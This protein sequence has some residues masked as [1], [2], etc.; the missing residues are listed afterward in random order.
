MSWDYSSYLGMFHEYHRGQSQASGR[1][2][3]GLWRGG[4]GACA[5]AGAYVMVWALPVAWLCVPHDG[6]PWIAVSS[7]QEGAVLP[8]AKEEQL[9]K[10]ANKLR[11]R[12][13]DTLWHAQAG[14][15]GG[16]LSA[17][18]IMATLFFEVM[19]DRSREPKVGG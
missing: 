1:P 4:R 3:D 19:R 10:L 16:S 5:P 11:R 8:R 6:M 7:H 9:Q 17:A 2:E 14:H 15:P 12:V 18:D 13:I